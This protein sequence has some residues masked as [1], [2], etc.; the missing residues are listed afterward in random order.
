MLTKRVL[1]DDS[2]GSKS[3]QN[4]AYAYEAIFVRSKINEVILTKI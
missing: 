3:P 2:A 4:L 1:L